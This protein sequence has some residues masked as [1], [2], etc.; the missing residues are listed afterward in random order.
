MYMFDNGLRTMYGSYSFVSLLFV[1]W[2]VYLTPC[3][4]GKVTGY[5]SCNHSGDEQSKHKKKAWLSISRKRVSHKFDVIT[6]GQNIT[7]ITC[8]ANSVLYVLH[9]TVIDSTHLLHVTNVIP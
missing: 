1:V 7:C 8:N 3:I 4:H 5:L 2:Y 6:Y 9:V